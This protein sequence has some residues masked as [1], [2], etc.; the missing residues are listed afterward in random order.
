M[1]NIFLY[2]FKFIMAIPQYSII[3]DFSEY[4]PYQLDKFCIFING[5]WDIW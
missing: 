3:F 4:L 5:R 2:K 1:I